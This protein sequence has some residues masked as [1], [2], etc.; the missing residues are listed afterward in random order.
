MR[1]LRA[2]APRKSR[3][4]STRS[5]RNST[6]NSAEYVESL[7]GNFAPVGS[8]NDRERARVCGGRVSNTVTTN[9]EARAHAGAAA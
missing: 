2:G 6:T 4:G 9:G 1:G 3:V 8:G 5:H 7:Y